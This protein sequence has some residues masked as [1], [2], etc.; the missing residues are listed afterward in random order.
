[1]SEKKICIDVHVPGE[2]EISV[3]GMDVGFKLKDAF[4]LEEIPINRYTKWF[5]YDI[6]QSG[7]SFRTRR[8]GDYITI[9]SEGQTQKLKSYFINEK[10]PKEERDNILLVADGS[11]VLWIFGYRSSY[12]YQ[13]TGYTKHVLEIQINEGE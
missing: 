3:L 13:I 9:N 2:Y 1:M 5:D 12:A 7:I 6:I 4:Q 10:I 8:A 11:H